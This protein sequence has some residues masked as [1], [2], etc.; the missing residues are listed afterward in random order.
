MTATILI[1]TPHAAFGELLRI[2]L[3]DSGQY[4]IHLVHTAKEARAASE[5]SAFHLAILDAV[6]VDQPFI[7]LCIDL[8]KQQPGVRLVVIPPDNNPNHPSLGGLMPHGYLSR[9]FY[10]PDLIDTVS[11]LLADREKQCLSQPLDCAKPV[12]DEHPS[13][14]VPAWL[15]EPLSLRG[16]LVDELARTQAIAAI[17]GLN[18]SSPGDRGAGAL[19]AV[20]GNLN[21]AAAQELVDI[22]FRYWNRAEKTDLMRF[23]RL[24]EDKL[25]YLVYATHIVGDLILILVYDTSAPLS[26]IRPQTKAMAQSL[27]T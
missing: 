24:N 2:S 12:S 11:R 23:V 8:L 22:V 19:R 10:L 5:H 17:A 21:D 25:D 9:P 13:P 4:Q 15:Q 16:C 18:I 14:A 7:P 26:Q 3:V 1:A 20:A 27:A 6:L